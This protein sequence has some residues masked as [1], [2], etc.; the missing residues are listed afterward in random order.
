MMIRDGRSLSETYDQGWY[1]SFGQIIML[2]A[3]PAHRAQA[4]E[5]FKSK[6]ACSRLTPHHGQH[7]NP[8]PGSGRRQESATSCVQTISSG[9]VALLRCHHL[10]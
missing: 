10:L 9:A 2:M 5:Q 6:A 3:G 8:I 1:N 4:L 7:I